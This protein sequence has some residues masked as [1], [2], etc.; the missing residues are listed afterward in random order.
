MVIGMFVRDVARDTATPTVIAKDVRIAQSVARW[1]GDESTEEYNGY[2][3]CL[4]CYREV[5]KQI[6][7][8]GR[9]K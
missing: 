2:H 7:C 1:C 4:S 3:Y 9:W 6:T 5:Q 8:L